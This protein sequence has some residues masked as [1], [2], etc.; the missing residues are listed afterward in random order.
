MVRSCIILRGLVSSAPLRPLA[1]SRR[2]KVAKDWLRSCFTSAGRWDKSRL[3]TM[4]K[5]MESWLSMGSGFECSSPDSRAI[6]L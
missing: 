5:L 4:E 6:S 2:W 3:S 1:S